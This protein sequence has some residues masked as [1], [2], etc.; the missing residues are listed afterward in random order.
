MYP[1]IKGITDNSFENKKHELSTPKDAL[2]QISQLNLVYFSSGEN[3]KSWGQQGLTTDKF[4]S[5]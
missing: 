2:W 4:S 3:I 1:S 5:L